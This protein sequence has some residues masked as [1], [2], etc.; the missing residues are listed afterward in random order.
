MKTHP[1]A[2]I[3]IISKLASKINYKKS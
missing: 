2:S 3:K 1:L